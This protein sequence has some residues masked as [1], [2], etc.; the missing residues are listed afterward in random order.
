MLIDGDKAEILEAINKLKNQVVKMEVYL[1]AIDKHLTAITKS[2]Y[3]VEMRIEAIENKLSNLNQ[4][5]LLGEVKFM[6][7][8]LLTLNNTNV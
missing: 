7:D 5:L 4:H 3:C 1:I 8:G 2:I 6:D